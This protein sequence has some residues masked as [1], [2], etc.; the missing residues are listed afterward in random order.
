MD[1]VYFTN[2]KIGDTRKWISYSFY[3]KSFFCWIC[4][5]FGLKDEQNSKFTGY[6]GG[7]KHFYGRI[8]EHRMS[9]T[10]INNLESFLMFDSKKDINS[11]FSKAR[12]IK[13]REIQYNRI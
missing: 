6:S 13:L 10:Y 4:I 11:Y 1:K 5:G 3:R 7:T 8:K 12:E 2:K 9:K